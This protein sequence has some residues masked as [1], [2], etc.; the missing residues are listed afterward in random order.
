[1]IVDVIFAVLGTILLLLHTLLSSVIALVI[2]TQVSDV[3]SL[4]FSQIKYF[5]GIWP[6]QQTLAA[7]TFLITIIM[8]EY[9]VKLIF[10]MIGFVRGTNSHPHQKQGK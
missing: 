1:M 5:Y 9:F 7:I 10:W 6:V 2:P 8:A 4:G 3:L